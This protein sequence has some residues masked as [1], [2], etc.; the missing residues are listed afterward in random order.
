MLHCDDMRF[1]QKPKTRS[2]MFCSGFF[3]FSLLSACGFSSVGVCTQPCV[4]HSPFYRNGILLSSSL[5]RGHATCRT[6]DQS[7]TSSAWHKGSPQHGFLRLCPTCRGLLLT[8]LAPFF[9]EDTCWNFVD[10]YILHFKCA[11]YCLNTRIP[12]RHKLDHSSLD[13]QEL[14]LWC[15]SIA[16]RILHDESR[17]GHPP[18]GDM[19]ATECTPS[20]TRRCADA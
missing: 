9:C 10:L 13:R 20:T 2:K 18:A 16:T 15:T 5:V 14:W 3:R 1:L 17:S 8:I 11:F 12:G 4:A 7:L 19:C 6:Q